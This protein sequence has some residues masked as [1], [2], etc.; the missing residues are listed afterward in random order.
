MAA[1]WDKFR[2]VLSNRSDRSDSNSAWIKK[3]NSSF[4]VTMGSYDGAE[5]CELV[6]L[7]ILNGLSNE[8]WKESIGLYRDDRLVIFENISRPKQLI[9]KHITR[10]FKNHRLKITIQTN[11]KIVNYLNVTLNLTNGSYYLYR[12]PNN[13]PQY[14]NIKSYHTPNICLLYTSPSPR[15]A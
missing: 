13:L 9:R 10:H 8:Y 3:N 7:F 4:D 15:D 6:G 1:L 14:I 12:K 2:S 11:L 5:V